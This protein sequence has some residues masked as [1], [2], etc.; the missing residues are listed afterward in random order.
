MYTG[1]VTY[2]SF[3]ELALFAIVGAFGGGRHIRWSIL[4]I[5]KGAFPKRVHTSRP[6]LLRLKYMSV[7]IWQQIETVATLTN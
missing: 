1:A 6:Q 3:L 7:I 2:T 5:G 4:Q